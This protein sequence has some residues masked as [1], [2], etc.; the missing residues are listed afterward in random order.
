MTPSERAAMIERKRQ[1]QIQCWNSL[2]GEELDAI[3]KRQREGM[4][5]YREGQKR[6]REKQNHPA[7]EAPFKKEA[8]S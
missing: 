7:V 4:Q 2:T 8:L 5:R 1:T 6:V 3:R